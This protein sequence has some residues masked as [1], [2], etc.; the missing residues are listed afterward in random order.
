MLT[1]FFASPQRLT[2]PQ[3][4]RPSV[5]LYTRP[6]ARPSVR[7]PARP[8]IHPPVRPATHPPAS[9]PVRPSARQTRFLCFLPLRFTGRQGETVRQPAPTSALLLEYPPCV[10][11]SDIISPFRPPNVRPSFPPSVRP[12]SE[13]TSFWP[14]FS[15]FLHHPSVRPSVC[16]YVSAF[17]CLSEGSFVRTYVCTFFCLSVRPSV[18][19]SVHPSSVR[20]SDHP[21]VRRTISPSVRPF[22]HLIH[23]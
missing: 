14:S 17:S 20:P 8:L 9:P 2:H 12:S 23:T 13:R 5:R 16:A 11:L 1:V 4:S 7:P 22:V 10:L 21:S 3:A 18:R 15:L 19:S 6:P